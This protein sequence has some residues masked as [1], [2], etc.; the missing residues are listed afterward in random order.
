MVLGPSGFLLV[1]VVYGVIVGMLLRLVW[2]LLGGDFGHCLWMVWEWFVV[3]FIYSFVCFGLYYRQLW[4][5][6]M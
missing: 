2:G 4:V 3:R 6:R 5:P 1:R